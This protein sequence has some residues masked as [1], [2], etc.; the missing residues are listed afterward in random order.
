LCGMVL[1]I[2]MEVLLHYHKEVE[3]LF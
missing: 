2:A 1:M 3:M